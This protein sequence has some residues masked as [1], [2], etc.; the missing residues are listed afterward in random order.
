[1]HDYLVQ[2]EFAASNLI[3][4][5]SSEE[6]TLN[7]LKSSLASLKNHHQFLYN[8]FLSKDSDPYDHFNEHQLM[9]AFAKQASF[10]QKH[11]EPTQKRIFEITLSVNAKEESI[12]ALAGALLQLAKQGISIVHGSPKHCVDGRTI[13]DEPIKTIIW[14]GRNQSLHY[15]EGNFRQPVTNCFNNIGIL[16]RRENLAKEII[17]LLNWN[18]Y[19]QYESDLRTLL[20]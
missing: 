7:D 16:L 1:M 17:D 20:E 8:D 3:K 14:E 5:I 11:I 15:E 4:L 19:K 9:H 10:N 12:K 6:N 18:T 2:T 13:K